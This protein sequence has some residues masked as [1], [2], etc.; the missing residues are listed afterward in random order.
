MGA[1]GLDVIEY[2]VDREDRLVWLS[3][4]WEPFARCN[5]APDLTA[6]RCLGRGLMEFVDGREPRYIWRELMAACRERGE[7]LPVPL[8]CDGTCVRRDMVATVTPQT[9]GGL[10][11]R[12]EAVAVEPCDYQA[13]LDRFVERTE[14]RLVA[15]S[16]CRAIRV[17]DE[18]LPVTEATVR[19]ALLQAARLPAITHGVCPACRATLQSSLRAC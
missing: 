11:F 7:P 17:E 5:G 9:D 10:R 1:S 4:S 2:E 12:V 3:S 8:R 19:L 6:A 15:C 13:I 16:W 14:G 18:W